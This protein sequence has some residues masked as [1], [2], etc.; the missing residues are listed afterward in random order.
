MQEV[1]GELIKAEAVAWRWPSATAT[2]APGKRMLA[3]GG[4]CKSMDGRGWTFLYRSQ[5]ISENQYQVGC[6]TPENQMVM[7]EAFIICQQNLI[8]FIADCL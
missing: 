5:P 4:N 1:V 2:C 3:G 8:Q 7:A 6:D